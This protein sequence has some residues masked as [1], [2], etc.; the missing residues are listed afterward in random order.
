MELYELYL[1]TSERSRNDDLTL[2]QTTNLI[3]FKTDSLLTIS[4]STKMT[5]FSK[6]E[7]NTVEKGEN[8]RYEQKLLVTRN[9]S[10]TTVFSKD[11]YCKHVKT[12]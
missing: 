8:A 12:S 4:D 11:L 1:T 5:K 9:S 10:F 7:E 3:L 2:S 6:G